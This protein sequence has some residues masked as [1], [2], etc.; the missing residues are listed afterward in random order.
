ML[1]LH[2]TGMH[3]GRAALERLC[4][5]ASG[6]SA[7]YLI[8]EDGTVFSLVDEGRR[9]WHAGVS[10]WRG[11]TDVNSASIGIELVNPGH[12]W[13]Y[14]PFPDEQIAA[15]TALAKDIV[16]RHAI[17]PSG[18]TGHSDIAPARKQDPGEWFP[19]Q[20]LAEEGIGLWPPAGLPPP[21][22]DAMAGLP[23]LLE[24]IGYASG[25]AP[26]TVQ[27]F[28]RRFLPENLG[29]P[30]DTETLGRACWLAARCK[31]S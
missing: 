29:R 6:V 27:A 5:P 1:V 19:W 4:D 9:A 7:H 15:L 13:G 8:E 3:T 21:D 10:W 24:C 20:R 23:A 16:R 25:P 2:Y 28:H 22:G 18:I 12:E 11:E 30:A 17:A 14:R 26:E 31:D